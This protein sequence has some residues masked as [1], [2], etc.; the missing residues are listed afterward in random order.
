V[1][2]RY[3]EDGRLDETFGS[4]GTLRIPIPHTLSS[5]SDVLVQPD[6]SLVATVRGTARVPLLRYATDGSLDGSFGNGGDATIERRA[7]SSGIALARQS[8]GKLLV[9]ASDGAPRAAGG[10]ALARVNADGSLDR[11]FA[12]GG[13]FTTARGPDYWWPSGL[14]IQP[15]GA[16]VVGGTSM[17]C[18]SRVVSLIR[19]RG[20]AGGPAADGAIRGCNPRRSKDGKHLSV[21]VDC[22]I[23]AVACKGSV[24]LRHRSV[25][26][27]EGRFDLHGVRRYALVRIA[28][29]R[30]ARR[31]LEH[32]K[33]V[34]ATAGYRVKRKS[35][36]ARTIVRRVTIRP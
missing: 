26:I 25:R 35:G 9:T 21:I 1:I 7:L 29:R 30:G 20:R 24:A 4:A 12:H 17:D 2:A 13:V 11:S 14:G 33:S 6:G 16:I 32:R 5:A 8:D 23:V 22:P 3:T 18:G 31:L 10:W 19:V 36:R 34:S 28:V 27:G 15:G